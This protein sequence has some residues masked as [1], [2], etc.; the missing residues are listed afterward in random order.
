MN[1]TKREPLLFT[2]FYKWHRWRDEKVRQAMRRYQYYYRMIELSF[3]LT[4]LWLGL[5]LVAPLAPWLVSSGT[6]IRTVMA[7]VFPANILFAIGLILARRLRDEHAE[8]VWQATA[9]RFVNFMVV[10]P[11]AIC[12]LF[13][14]FSKQ[15]QVQAHQVLPKELITIAVQAKDPLSLFIAGAAVTMLILTIFVPQLFIVFYRWG[16]WRDSR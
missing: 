5:K 13:V 11:L 1:L 7:F 2:G 8:R 4:M 3:W 6:P 12:G 16:L 14:L 9:R 10:A 15:I